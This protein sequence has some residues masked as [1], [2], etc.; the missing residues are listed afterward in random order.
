MADP[1][2]V[3]KNGDAECDLLSGLAHR[4]GLKTSGALV[5]RRDEKTRP[6]VTR[7]AF[8]L[9]PG[10]PITAEPRKAPI[11]SSLFAVGPAVGW[12]FIRG[13]LGSIRGG[14]RRR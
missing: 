14:D 11:A 3:A 5:S 7:R 13:V 4:H 10:G 12:Q 6:S 9:P 2:L 1:I 8:V